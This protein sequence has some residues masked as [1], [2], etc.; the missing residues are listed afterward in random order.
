MKKTLL[1]GMALL[2]ALL[3]CTVALS[4]CSGKGK[5]LMTLQKDGIS[6]SF[7]V[8]HYELMLSRMK[9]T[10]VFNQVTAGG[11]TA[12][13]SKFW[14]YT[15]YVEGKGNIT[16]D[17]HYRTSILDNCRTTLVSLYLFEQ[18]GLSLSDAALEK[19]DDDLEELIRT[20]GNGSKTKLNSV[21][22][23]FGVN[24][25]MLREAYIISAKVEAVQEA[26]YG[27]KAEMI[28]YNIKNNYLNENYVH[29]RQIFLEE[30][31]YVYETD[32]NG[33]V[34]YYYTEEGNNKGHVYYDK[35]NGE[36]KLLENGDYQTDDRDD[37]IYYVKGSDYKK[38]AYD[39]TNGQPSIVRSKDGVSYETTPMTDDEKKVLKENATKLYEQVKDL[40]AQ[41]FE[42]QIAKRNEDLG[43]SEV[44]TDG[45]YLRT[46]TDYL[47]GGNTYE[48]LQ[49][50]VDALQTM[51]AGEVMMVKSNMGYHIIMKY[52]HAEK[53]YEKE[54]NEV[55]F[56]DF[57]TKLI[58]E[59]YL[60]LCKSYYNDIQVDEAVLAK[61]PTMK[62]VAVNYY[63]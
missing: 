39:S 57:N 22:A 30:Y 3:T 50:I 5:T 52:N 34:I 62:E 20:D 45:Y 23:P 21:L 49:Q 26:L 2:L 1:R 48:Y 55:W 43:I 11:Y 16:L 14:E 19:I 51:E 58:E 44:Y 13:Q 36:R 54:E 12:N 61:A 8:N 31:H 33:D 28:G 40:S 38:I 37:E 27:A 17:E 9:G 18:K 32:K 25:D 15:D 59:L 6:V 10:L 47:S 56:S 24:Y 4:A 63:Y 35:H 41:D 53:A 7:S 29:F 46:D 60:E 42:A